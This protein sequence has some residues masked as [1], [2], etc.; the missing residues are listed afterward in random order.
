MQ[1]EASAFSAV[2]LVP[3]S[4]RG[5]STVKRSPVLFL[6][7]TLLVSGCVSQQRVVFYP[8]EHFEKVGAAEAER[9]YQECLAKAASAGTGDSTVENAA[10]R[11]AKA[12]VVGG[13][14]GAV[15]GAV[16]GHNVGRA[17]GASAAGAATGGFVSGMLRDQPDPVTRRFIEKCLG[18]RGYSTIGWR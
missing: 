8:N 2:R 15:H 13:S 1:R 12:A 6:C 11:G 14:A 18:E 5:V 7:A 16:R 3:P 4:T 10:E 9:D 17:A